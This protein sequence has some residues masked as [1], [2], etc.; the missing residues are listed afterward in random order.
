MSAFDGPRGRFAPVLAAAIVVSLNVGKL[1]PALPALR[2]E[3]G[4]DLVAASLLISGFQIAG[5]LLGLFGGMLA[6]R[7]G[8]RR[9]MRIGLVVTAAGSAAGAL[10]HDATQMLASRAIESLGFILTVLPGPALV[11]RM[12][13]GERLRRSMGAWSTYL[14]A[15]MATALALSPPIHDALGWRAV[16]WGIALASLAMAVVL[17]RAVA[18]DPGGRPAHGALA[19]IRD[20]LRAPRV[21]VLSAAFGCYA[22]Q[23]IGVFSFLPTLYTEAGIALSAAGLLTAGGVAVN[24]VGNLASGALLQR[25]L[26]RAGL[27]VAG[28]AAMMVGAWLCFASPAPFG[29]RYAGVLLFSAA[30]G[31]IPGTLF[32]STAAYAPH[33]RAV[34]TATGL[35]QQ[36][37]TLG[38][39]VA[40]PLIAA[41]V[42][43][44]GG[45]P[46]AVWATGALALGCAGAAVAMA[47]FDRADARRGTRPGIG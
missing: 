15:G 24:L 40:P 38:Q 17:G 13:A 7:F 6:D 19:L 27:V 14:P 2:S 4:L 3:F 21:W 39:F 1:P 34:G 11:A 47:A 26:P 37:S 42:S 8:P 32:A 29:V 44:S 10:A 31:L 35:M 18:P 33:P 22:A 45:W 28:S 23:W 43:A 12:V 25:G 9:V 46:N 30:G 16:W 36:G 20:T 5:M 41:A